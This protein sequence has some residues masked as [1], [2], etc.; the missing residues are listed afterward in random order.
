MI[1]KGK[2]KKNRLKT[3]LKILKYQNPEEKFK[4]KKALLKYTTTR[5]I[6]RQEKNRP[7]K[8]QIVSMPHKSL[9]GV[10]EY[11]RAGSQF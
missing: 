10:G 7:G 11:G 4:M 9:Q 6:L 5:I 2:K 1:S 8:E 3:R